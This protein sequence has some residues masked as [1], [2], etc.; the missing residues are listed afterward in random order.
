MFYIRECFAYISSRIFMV[1][2]LMFKS[3]SHF[4]FIFVHGVRVCSN[5]I[6]LHATIQLSQYHLPRM[7]LFSMWSEQLLEIISLLLHLLSLISHPSMWSVLENLPRALEKK[8][9][10]G[11]KVLKISIKSLIVLFYHLGS[12]LP[13]DFLS[14]RSFH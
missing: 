1:S 3:L 12:L 7:L 9:V 8:C 10:F 14:Q 13:I 4:E 5:F 2:Y 11:C 6:D